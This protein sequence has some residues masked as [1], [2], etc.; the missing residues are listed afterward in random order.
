MLKRIASESIAR[1]PVLSEEN[2]EQIYTKTQNLRNTSAS[3]SATSA[4][5]QSTRLPVDIGISSL[6]Q[7]C[8]LTAAFP[9]QYPS[10]SAFNP[11]QRTIDT[12]TKGDIP[13][14]YVGVR[15]LPNGDV[16]ASERSL[17]SISSSRSK[18]QMTIANNE[19]KDESPKTTQISVKKLAKAIDVCGDMGLW[20]E[21][22]R[23]EQRKRKN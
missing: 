18:D 11:N 21:W 13:I 15:I 19:K 14:I 5:Q 12:V 23:S 17:E 16:K 20:V 8:F 9:L 2:P 10:K 1:N 6:P 22:I 4:Q 7:E 3:A